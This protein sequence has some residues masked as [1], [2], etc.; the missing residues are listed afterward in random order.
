[1][2]TDLYPRFSEQI[3]LRKLRR[4]PVVL[5]HGPRQ[6]GKTTLA[7][8]IGDA[9]GYEYFTLDDRETREQAVADPAG[10]IDRC[11][12]RMVLDEVQRNPDIFSAIKVAVDRDRRAGKRDGGRFLLTGSAQVLLLPQ[13]SDS[14]AGRM[15]KVRLHPLSRCELQGRSSGF[16]DALFEDG[17][18]AQ[19]LD[20]LGS[21]LLSHVMAGGYPEVQEMEAGEARAPPGTKTIWMPRSSATC[22]TWPDFANPESCPRC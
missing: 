21:E 10:F 4:S 2:E 13:I 12:G 17:F 18:R 15:Q 16:L 11:P 8:E 22:A 9:G 3:L 7:Q 6:C 14:L 19:R 5:L 20:S 1:M